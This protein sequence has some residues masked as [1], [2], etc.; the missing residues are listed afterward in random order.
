M[1][2]DGV[3]CKIE[4]ELAEDY[5]GRDRLLQYDG[6]GRAVSAVVTTRDDGNDRAVLAPCA[7]GRLRE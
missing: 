7:L 1:V 5:Q 6:E 4:V 2:A 3:L